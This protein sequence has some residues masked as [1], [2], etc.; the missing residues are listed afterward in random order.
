MRIRIRI[1][2]IHNRNGAFYNVKIPGAE[3]GHVPRRLGQRVLFL[4]LLAD[5][6]LLLHIV[7]TH[8]KLSSIVDNR[9]KRENNR[10]HTFRHKE[11]KTTG[12]KVFL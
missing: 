5:A 12:K 1:K 2:V 11:G 4:L 3:L 7:K 6:A 10:K 8:A 9:E